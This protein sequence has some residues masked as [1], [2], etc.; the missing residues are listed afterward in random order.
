MAQSGITRTGSGRE[1][2]AADGLTSSQW[3][4]QGQ[5]NA[6]PRSHSA[7]SF[8]G[9]T[10]APTE[11]SSLSKSNVEEKA[12]DV[13]TIKS[14]AT[15]TSGGVPINSTAVLDPA[16]FNA[17]ADA[18]KQSLRS[19]RSSG[20]KDDDKNDE[21]D[22]NL[23]E[24][25]GPDDKGNP[26]NFPEWRK[27]LITATS[28][29]MTFTVTFASSV[30]STATMSTAKEF[31]VSSE[32]MVLG[33]SLFV[34][35][36]AFGPLIWGPFSELYGRKLPL[37]IGF[38]IFAIFQIPVALAQNLQTIFICRFFGGFFASAPLAVVGGLLADLFNPIDRGIAIAVFSGATFIGPVAGPIVGGFITQSYLG[39]RWTAW[40]TCIMAFSFG[41]VGVIV[42]PETFEAVL[43]QQR[44][45]KL[46]FETKNWA[47]HAK[48]DENQVNL[49]EISNKYLLRP[50]IMLFLE[51]ILL[52]ITLYMG[53]IY[54]F[55]YLCFEAY[56]IAFQE[57]RG[58]NLGVGALPFLAILVGV[59]CGCL[60]IS[61]FSKT[62][63]ARKLEAN[64]GKP[65]P[66]ERLLPM[67]LGGALLPIGMFWF[68]WTSN[69]NIIWVPQVISGA[70]IGA[71][72]FVLFLSRPWND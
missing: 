66:E 30:F 26:Q 48:A 6:P 68:A 58:W 71:G 27:W 46:R 42:V 53:F 57:E 22:P 40:I 25:D 36:F 23:V 7:A 3:P 31:G 13:R 60:I 43:L 9:S 45:K 65:V 67:I 2:Y 8:S 51:P 33:T 41:L 10:R 63:F 4:L 37:F 72:K 28:G 59:I 56:P 69:P 1:T 12:G 29:I 44:A 17:G 70:F 55:L 11:R 52:L 61:Y 21:K 38:F 62:R 15:T 47:L 39:W 50:F 19:Q 18:E 24:W 49:K 14:D 35:G 34:L 16:L 54:G 64:G 20:A 32:V 5:V